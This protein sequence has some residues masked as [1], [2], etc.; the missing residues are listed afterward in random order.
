MQAFYLLS[1]S[2]VGAMIWGLAGR[3]YQRLLLPQLPNT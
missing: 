1:S 3:L 2:V